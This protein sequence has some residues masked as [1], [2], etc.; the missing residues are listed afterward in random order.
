ML[1]NEQAVCPK[2]I[3]SVVADFRSNSHTRSPALETSSQPQDASGDQRQPLFF[4]GGEAQ[5][6]DLGSMPST[7]RHPGQMTSPTHPVGPLFP[8]P[9]SGLARTTA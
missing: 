7:L 1:Y 9:D 8:S 5:L 2:G 6:P 4:A 3:C